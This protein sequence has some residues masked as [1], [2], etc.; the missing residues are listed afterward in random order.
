MIDGGGGMRGLRVAMILAWLAAWAGGALA[1]TAAV[2]GSALLLE[3][4]GVIGPASR[5]FILRGFE[6]ARERGAAA[7]ILKLDTPGGLDSSMRDIIQAIL[8]SPVP[9]IGYVAPEGARAA[10]AGTYML[11][12][13]HIAAMAPATNLGA[14]TPVQL[15][16]LPLPARPTDRDRAHEPD[17]DKAADKPADQSTDK[18]TPATSDM[19]RK[20][21]NDARA[22]IR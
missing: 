2:P 22:Y 3:V 9:V 19:E 7:I 4:Q 8:A 1:M 11:Y 16:G 12:A 5:D 14:A 10:S 13:C 17:T 18:P 15:G 20:L 6:Q 21:V